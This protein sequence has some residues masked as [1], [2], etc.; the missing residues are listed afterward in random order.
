MIAQ[1]KIY[2]NCSSLEPTKVYTLYRLTPYL[3]GQLQEFII[4]KFNSQELKSLNGASHDKIL[5]KVNEKYDEVSEEEL[6][7]DIVRLVR[8]FFPEITVDE[9]AMCDFGD[10]TGANGQFY[11]FLNTVSDYAMAQEQRAAKN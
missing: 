4:K 3:K 2:G 1:L 6:K 11:E 9:L 8:L 5:S 10:N 7:D